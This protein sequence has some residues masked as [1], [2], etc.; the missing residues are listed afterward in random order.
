MKSEVKFQHIVFDWRQARE[1]TVDEAAK[2][3]ARPSKKAQLRVYD[4]VLYE[5]CVH[6]NK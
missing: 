6:Q 2:S 3:V 5:R 1:Q 4:R